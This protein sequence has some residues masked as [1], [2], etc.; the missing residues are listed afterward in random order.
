[1]FR[2]EFNIRRVLHMKWSKG[3]NCEL[4]STVALRKGAKNNETGNINDNF[5]VKLSFLFNLEYSV[6]HKYLYNKSTYS[7]Q[8]QLHAMV[9]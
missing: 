2:F 7:C 9:K 8:L 6:I 3:R 4:Y 5:T 1:M